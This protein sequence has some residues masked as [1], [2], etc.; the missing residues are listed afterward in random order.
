MYTCMRIDN[1]G[2]SVE[3][4]PQLVGHFLSEYFINNIYYSD[5]STIDSLLRISRSG[6]QVSTPLVFWMPV[7]LV[8]KANPQRRSLCDPGGCRL[9]RC[10]CE[11]WW[12]TSEPTALHCSDQLR[13][14]SLLLAYSFRIWL[15][16]WAGNDL[17][18]SSSYGQAHSQEGRN[19]TTQVAISEPVHVGHNY[20]VTF[21]N[22]IVVGYDCCSDQVYSFDTEVHTPWDPGKSALRHLPKTSAWGQAEFQ[23]GR[24][25]MTLTY[26]PQLGLP[27]RVI[28]DVLGPDD[29]P[30][31]STATC[32]H[33]EAT[34]KLSRRITN[35]NGDSLPLPLFCN[36]TPFS[37]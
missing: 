12:N 26:L 6:V 8:D 20:Y 21:A 28:D 31:V 9:A 27:S 34:S 2:D 32:T 25:V 1:S 24:N 29:P 36:P 15:V 35:R 37:C 18:L 7:D 11:K 14:L 16:A 33:K 23:E 30:G 10:S 19:V 13:W 22:K 17:E 3:M 4:I 5:I